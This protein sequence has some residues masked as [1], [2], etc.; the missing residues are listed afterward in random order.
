MVVPYIPQMKRTNA[1]RCGGGFAEMAFADGVMPNDS[2]DP[3][4]ISHRGLQKPHRHDLLE[5][6]LLD[7]WL[8][9][10]CEIKAAA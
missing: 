10:K 9:R 1:S 3:K 7:Q 6:Y 2:S 5:N 4:I 8:K